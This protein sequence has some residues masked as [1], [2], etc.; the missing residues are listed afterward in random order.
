MCHEKLARLSL[1]IRDIARVRTSHRQLR[2]ILSCPD[3]A[4]PSTPGW[5]WSL[6]SP[7]FGADAL[8]QQ[9]YSR[10]LLEQS[11]LYKEGEA[12]YLQ[13]REVIDSAH[14]S[15]RGSCS[16]QTQEFG[17]DVGHR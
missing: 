6:L 14:G 9:A 5:H 17:F 8:Y 10:E 13:Q 16:Q 7:M 11:S 3:L 15:I 12:G 4:Q 1:T 2:S